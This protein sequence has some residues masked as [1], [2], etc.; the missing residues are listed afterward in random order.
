MRVCLVTLF[1]MMS[2]SA[3]S[4]ACVCRCVDGEARAICGSTYDSKPACAQNLCPMVSPSRPIDVYP[5]QPIGR[6][7]CSQQQVLNTRTGQY[8]W[9]QLC[10]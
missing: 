3:A 7:G 2:V 9:R 8:E 5:T 6:P 1:L 10:Q 4:A